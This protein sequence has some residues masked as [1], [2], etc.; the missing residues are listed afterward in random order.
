MNQD[1]LI[2]VQ[3]AGWIVVANVSQ[4]RLSIDEVKKRILETAEPPDL[5]V[6]PP[7]E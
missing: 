7:T 5:D 1:L 3:L 2:D 4:L 6:K